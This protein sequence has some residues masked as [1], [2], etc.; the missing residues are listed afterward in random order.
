MTEQLDPVLIHKARTVLDL[1]AR[2]AREDICVFFELV[3]RHET[4][5][6]PLRLAEHQKVALS[7]L[8]HHRRCG[9]IMPVRHSKTWMAACL[10]LWLLGRNP[11]LR[12]A[13]VSATQEQAAKVLGMVSDYILNSPELKLVFPHLRETQRS[14]E[15]WT[16]VAITVDRPAGIRDASLKAIG[17]DGAIAGSRLDWIVIDDVLNQENTLTLEGCK[18]TIEWLDSSVMTRLEPSPETRVLGLNTPWHT[19]DAIHEFERRGW[20]MM[21]MSI[22]G[23]IRVQDDADEILAAKEDGRPYEHWDH[24]G[25][26]P[27]SEDPRDQTLRLTE[28]APGSPLWPE[29][30]TPKVVRVLKRG[31][32]I[33]EW[34]RAYMCTATSDEEAMCKLEYVEACKEAARKARVHG[35]VVEWPEN[36]G[37]L[38]AIDTKQA[39][40]AVF[41]GVDLAVKQ[42]QQHDLTAFFTFAVLPDGRRRIL[43]IESGRF[44][45]PQI[46]NKIILKHRQFGGVMIVEDVG[47]FL[48]GSNVLTIDGYKP[49]EMIKV[50]ELVWT[51]AN[52]WR[53]VTEVLTGNA[54]VLVKFKVSG[55][56][57]VRCTPN[58]WVRMRRL[59]R[60]HKGHHRPTGDAQWVSAG[61]ID[62]PAFVNVAIP[63]WPVTEP[64]IVLNRTRKRRGHTLTVDAEWA[65]F[66]GLFMA[67]G[68]ASETQVTWTLHRKERHIVR[69]IDRQLG[70]IGYG[71]TR[72]DVGNT[73]RIVVSHK[74]LATV[75]RAFGT[76]SQKRPPRE[77]WGWPVHLRLA[78][79]RGWLMG[80]GCLLTNRADGRDPLRYF[81][82]CSISRDWIMLVRAT[83]MELGYRASVSISTRSTSVIEGRRVDRK[84]LY[85]LTLNAE[86]SARLRAEMTSDAEAQHWEPLRWSGRASNSRMT[87]DDQGAWSRA[88]TGYGG[89]FED[90]AK[91]PVYNLVVEEDHSYVVE[92][93][94]V[95]NAQDYIRQ[96]TRKEDVSIPVRPYATTAMKKANPVYGVATVFTEMAN[97]AW[98]FP[99]DE[100]GHMHPE[101]RKYV[102][103][104]LAYT[105]DEHVDDV[106]MAQFFAREQARRWGLLTPEQKAAQGIASVMMR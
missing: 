29:V 21:R 48:G 69:F 89:P 25:I 28:H 100:H 37:G 50:G 14:R 87:I 40:L 96:F 39:A 33:H 58:H 104:C 8:M 41:T 98:L 45:G 7:F 75:L 57:S 55:C 95:H 70:R 60:S 26:E 84:P 72:R 91:R 22:D 42:G 63:Q 56:V 61:V 74:G 94:V 20:A 92:D 13:I 73:A 30:F 86:D 59:G 38:N 76:S 3:M 23:T 90:G 88:L 106:L 85:S 17:L 44:T 15:P 52:R 103:A 64:T 77:W 46:V 101:M 78:M 93:L 49:I 81:E 80:D 34:N 10:T 51:H 16:Q 9:L 6:T 5:R 99:N 65:L 36:R 11:S 12:G 2:L 82:G 102:D 66:L 79:I 24:P 67:E 32:P 62:Q 27:R 47:C 19:K 1:W 105:P 54:H 83:L 35:F 18:K 71:V 4:R 68:H 31:T 43:D 53:P 97:G